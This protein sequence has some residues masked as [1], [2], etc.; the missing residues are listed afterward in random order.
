MFRGAPALDSL[1]DNSIQVSRSVTVAASSAIPTLDSRM[2]LLLL[3]SVA[4][5]A[6]YRLRH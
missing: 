4:F 2:I 6:M 3:V 1:S 5:V